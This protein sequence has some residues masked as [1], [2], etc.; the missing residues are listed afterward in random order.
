[1]TKKNETFCLGSLTAEFTGDFDPAGFVRFLARM[2]VPE[3]RVH[4]RLEVDAL[5]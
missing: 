1:M 5:E 3:G 2:P 4:I